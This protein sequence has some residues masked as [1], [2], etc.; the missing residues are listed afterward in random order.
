MQM[1]GE[2]TDGTA[3]GLTVG[4]PEHHLADAMQTLQ[5]HFFQT[6]SSLYDDDKGE[7][8]GD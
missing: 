6:T 5:V 1:S 7:I 8:Q 3:A 2:G 4:G